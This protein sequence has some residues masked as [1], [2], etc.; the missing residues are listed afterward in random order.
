M[1]TLMKRSTLL[2][3]AVSMGTKLEALDSSTCL[4]SS[5]LYVLLDSDRTTQN[6]LE[7][8]NIHALGDMYTLVI[9]T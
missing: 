8:V 1:K 6:Y 2:I 4:Q 7:Q 9:L 3:A 5:P